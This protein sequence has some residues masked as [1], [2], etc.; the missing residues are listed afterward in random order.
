MNNVAGL[1]DNDTIKDHNQDEA[2]GGS[3]SIGGINRRSST[4][5]SRPTSSLILADDATPPLPWK[6]PAGQFAGT[7]RLSASQRFS[8]DAIADVGGNTEAAQVRRLQYKL[9]YGRLVGPL[10]IGTCLSM[11]IFFD[12]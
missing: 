1:W 5:N 8:M 12:H 4:A 7:D 6:E 9:G 3:G 11:F 2:D 10:L